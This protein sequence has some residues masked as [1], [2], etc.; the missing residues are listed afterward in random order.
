M[1]ELTARRPELR[2][3]IMTTVPR[4][5]FEQSLT[6]PFSLHRIAAD[7]GLVQRTPLDEDLDATVR[8]L[9]ALLGEPRPVLHRLIDRIGRLRCRVVISDIAPLG[10]AAAHR[11]G[12]PAVL[13]ENFTWD[14]IYGGYADL[15]SRIAVHAATMAELAATADLHIQTDP[16]CRRVDGALLVPPVARRPRLSPERVRSEL[17]VPTDTPVVLLTMGGVGWSYQGLERLAGPRRCWFV[18]PGGASRRRRS[19]QLVLL[20]FRSKLFHP[21]LVRTADVVVGKLGY[22][23]VAEVYHARAAMAYV[24]RSRFRESPVLADFVSRV[25]PSAEVSARELDDGGG[26]GRSTGSSRRHAT[27]DRGTTARLGPPRRS[28]IDSVGCWLAGRTDAWCARPRELGP[29]P[30]VADRRQ[31]ASASHHRP[32]SVSCF[33]ERGT[34]AEREREEPR[35]SRGSRAV[36]VAEAHHG[37]QATC[38]TR[39]GPPECC[40][41][42]GLTRFGG[43]RCTGPGLHGGLPSSGDCGLA[44]LAARCASR[45]SSGAG[46]GEGGIRTRGG[47]APTHAFQACSFGHSDTS[48]GRPSRSSKSW[49]RGRD[50]NPW[51]S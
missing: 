21:D 10:I 49:R 39:R 7:V 48:P 8:R 2:F 31:V 33:R 3:H 27:M 47:V 11:L 42:P 26:C 13:I 19:G 1:T 29:C 17:G 43:R 6:T 46:G 18:V 25:G 28:S 9:D 14:W 32:A 37:A 12:I 38:G 51:T 44:R 35:P 45:A 23:T 41:L 5:F 22:S 50:S 20:P 4:W 30:R 34:G 24:G 36:E 15:E 16:V 40:S